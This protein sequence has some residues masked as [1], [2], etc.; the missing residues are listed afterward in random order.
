MTM[1]GEL[2]R[3]VERHE[4]VVYR[5]SQEEFAERLGIPEWIVSVSLVTGEVV[6]H[7]KAG[8]EIVSDDLR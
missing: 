5:M 8:D 2:K 4:W 1:S 6:I 7:A 3:D